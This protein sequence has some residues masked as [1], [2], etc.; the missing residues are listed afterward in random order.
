MKRSLRLLAC[1]LTV[2]AV[3]AAV[4]LAASSPT[5]STGTVSGVQEFSAVLHGIVKPNG[6]PTT[7][8]FEWGLTNAY[9][10]ITKPRSAGH[11]TKDVAVAT[12]ARSLLPGTRYHYR[13]IATSKEGQT[14]GVDRSFKTGGKPPAQAA[15][16]SA[17]APSASSITVNGIVNPEGH[18]TSW[19][20][21]YG[22]TTSYGSR[23]VGGTLPATAPASVVS[24]TIQGLASG[25]EFHYEL[26]A[27]NRGVPAF[28]GDGVFMTFPSPAPVPKV[29]AKTTPTR[30]RHGPYVFTTAGSISGPSSIPSAF[31]CGGQVAIHFLLHTRAVGTE[32]ATVGPS[33]TFSGQTVFQRK[34]GQGK[35][36]RKVPLHV[37]INYRGDG[38][39]AAGKTGSENVTIG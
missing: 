5:V 10:V 28:G 17:T 15:T 7:Y 25:T 3:S 6:D 39:L 24:E 32:I 20:F 35:K 31:A 26:V 2:G 13:L 4:A 21:N 27:V 12:T 34:P 30:D 33:C 22:L 11:G 37:V 1:A 36:N 9:G 38:Y 19:Y 18:D 14:V 8:Q 23:T 29:R 16:G